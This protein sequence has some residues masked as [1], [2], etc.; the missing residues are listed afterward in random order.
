MKKVYLILLLAVIFTIP[1]AWN[2]VKFINCD[3]ELS[4][5][6]EIVHG[7]GILVP[8]SAYVTVWFDDDSDK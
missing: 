6:C 8:P 4:W 1:W 2:A 7:V 5:E 3:F